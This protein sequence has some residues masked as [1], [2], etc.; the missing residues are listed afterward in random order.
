MIFES[1]IEQNFLIGQFFFAQVFMFGRFRTTSSKQPFKFTVWIN[2]F[3]PSPS[4]ICISALLFGYLSDKY[5]RTRILHIALCWEILGGF[6]SIFANNIKVFTI[7]R[8]FLSI[9]T[10]GRNLTAFL[11]CIECV[12]SLYRAKCGVGAF[13]NLCF[14]FFKPNFLNP[15]WFVQTGCLSDGL[16]VWLRTPTLDS[17]PDTWLCDDVLDHNHTGVL[18]GNLDVLSGWIA[19]MVD[20]EGS[21]WWGWGGAAKGIEDQQYVRRKSKAD[22]GGIPKFG[23]RWRGWRQNE[24]ELLQSVE[25]TAHQTVYDHLVL[26]LVL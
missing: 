25:I 5:G 22:V 9:G 16:G 26:H 14:D 10:Y 4:G 2:R 18:L 3:S 7:A 20:I 11:L 6:F 12:G 21:L 19:Q 17:L 24:H 8:F 23:G 15:L 1:K 13:F